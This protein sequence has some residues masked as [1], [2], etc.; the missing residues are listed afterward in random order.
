MSRENT[1]GPAHQIELVPRGASVGAKAEHSIDQ[2]NSTIIKH[3]LAQAHQVKGTLARASSEVFSY[4]L[5]RGEAKA[6]AKQGCLLAAP[7]TCPKGSDGEVRVPTKS[8]ELPREVKEVNT[9]ESHTRL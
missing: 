4:S 3:V 7:Y 8:R 1:S 5:Q 2:S 9:N 6:H